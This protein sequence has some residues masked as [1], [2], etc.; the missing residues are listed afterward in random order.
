MKTND[1]Q[2]LTAHLAQPPK[3]ISFILYGYLPVTVALTADREGGSALIYKCTAVVGREVYGDDLY[4]FTVRLSKSTVEAVGGRGKAGVM[5]HVARTHARRY[6]DSGRG[7]FARYGSRDRLI[8]GVSR[9]QEIDPI[10]RQIRLL[11][12]A[13]RQDAM[14]V[15]NQLLH[16]R[17]RDLRI[18]RDSGVIGATRQRGETWLR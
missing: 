7:V 9:K 13:K 5:L 11:K 6:L 18:L 16:W 4:P 17:K 12:G 15:V 1:A 8:V 14:L 2:K 3:I 10:T